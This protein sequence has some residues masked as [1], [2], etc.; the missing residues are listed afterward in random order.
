MKPKNI[1]TIVYKS[2]LLNKL[3]DKGW[4]SLITHS[5]ALGV[6]KIDDTILLNTTLFC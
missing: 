3:F 2:A 6:N 1:K 4:L 5:R